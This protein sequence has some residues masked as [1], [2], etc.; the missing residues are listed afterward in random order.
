MVPTRAGETIPFTVTVAFLEA[1]LTHILVVPICHL[2]RPIVSPK[3]P[4]RVVA[5]LADDLKEEPMSHP[6]GGEDP[7]S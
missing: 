4:E 7:I 1:Q 6:F 5:A 3:G 2:A